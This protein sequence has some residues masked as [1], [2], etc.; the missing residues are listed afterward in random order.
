MFSTQDP[1]LFA[2]GTGITAAIHIFDKDKQIRHCEER[3]DA[4]IQSTVHFIDAG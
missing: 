3:S 4:A 2:D 1:T